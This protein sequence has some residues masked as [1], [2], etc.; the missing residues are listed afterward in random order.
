MTANHSWSLVGEDVVEVAAD[1][2]AGAGGAEE[3]AELEPLGERQLGRQ[4]R[5]L[6]R[7]GD[8][9]ALAVEPRVVDGG[10]RAQAE[11]LGEGEVVLV[12]GAARLGADEGDRADHLLARPHRDDHRRHHP[13]RPDQGEV[14]GVHGA[15]LE[16]I[17]RDVRRTARP[18]P[19]AA[20]APRPGRRGGRSDT[21]APA[22]RRR[23]AC[24][25]RRASSTRARARRGRRGRSRTSR[26]SRAPPARRPARA[27]ARCPATRRGRGSPRPGSAGR[28]RPAR[29]R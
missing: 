13:D 1:L 7:V 15:L 25:G 22:P 5:R 12:E 8:R 21:G 19:C 16:Q 3:R 29:A 4:Q 18:R 26:R 24:P 9:R 14:L 23:P 11:V 20:R 10:P 17:L 27:C 28:T 6:Q 2:D